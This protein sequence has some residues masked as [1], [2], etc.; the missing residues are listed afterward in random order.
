MVF[1]RLAFTRC[2]TCEA[3]SEVHEARST[4][5]TTQKGQARP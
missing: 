4:I 3:G 1:A 5:A 2:Q